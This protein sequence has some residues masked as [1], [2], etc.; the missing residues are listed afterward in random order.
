MGLAYGQMGRLEDAGR[1][2]EKAVT[3]DP[4][5]ETAHGSLAMWY[6]R[7]NDFGSADR[8]Y[9]RAVSLDRSDSWAEMGLMRVHEMQAG[10]PVS[11]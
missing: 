6:E 10:R 7:T 3:L 1:A 5:P 2:L 11:Y 9:R 4:D 8:E